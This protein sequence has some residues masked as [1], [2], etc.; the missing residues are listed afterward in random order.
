MLGW[1]YWEW[2]RFWRDGEKE[3][4]QEMWNNLHECMRS[5]E[6]CRGN[7]REEKMSLCEWLDEPAGFRF[8]ACRVQD[9]D[10]DFL[11]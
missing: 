11:I 3:Y 5:R 4:R 8:A 9:N 2:M 1:N 10:G 6:E 7:S